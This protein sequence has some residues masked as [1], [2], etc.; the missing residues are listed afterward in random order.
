MKKIFS[1]MAVATALFAGYSTYNVQQNAK[2]TDIAWAN[3][4]ALATGAD[5]T[6]STHIL[7]CGAAGVKM[8]EATCNRCNVTLRAYG[9]GKTVKLTCPLN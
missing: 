4:E 5:A 2:L 9:N 1:I 3:V 8:C 7:D 6:N